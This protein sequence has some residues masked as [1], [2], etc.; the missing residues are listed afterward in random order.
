MTTHQTG[1][2]HPADDALSGADSPQIEELQLTIDDRIVGTLARPRD[3]RNLPAV[4]LLHGFASHRD[5]VGDLFKRLASILAS[6]GIVSLRI[7]FPGSGDSPGQ[8]V[9]NISARV[10]A[11]ASAYRYL[12]GIPE[13]DMSRIGVLG[14]SMGG[15]TAR[16]SAA[17]HPEWYRSMAAWSSAFNRETQLRQ[18]VEASE[19]DGITLDL[20]FRRV[21]IGQDFFEDYALYDGKHLELIAC[22]AGPYLTIVGSEDFA[23]HDVLDFVAHAGGELREGVIIGCEGHIFEV[24]S[25]DQS[26]AQRVLDRTLDWFANT[27]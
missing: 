19:G 5:E 10:D 16:I 24:L 8:F 18:S 15:V 2:R 3:A 14:F 27:L 26:K 25:Q 21:T 1:N 20:G 11:A 22:Y 9:S 13:V 17:A 12:A 6:H 7:D 4:L 23:G